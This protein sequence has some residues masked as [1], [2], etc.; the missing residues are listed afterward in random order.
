MDVDLRSNIAAEARAKI[1]YER[2]INFTD[3]L[4][5]IE[6]LQFL[7]GVHG[8]AGEHGKPAF[9]I[10]MIPPTPGL[11]NQYFDD[12]TGVGDKG[13]SMHEVR[14]IQG[15][16][17]NPWAPAFAQFASPGAGTRQSNVHS[18]DKKP[19]KKMRELRVEELQDVLHA[20][21]QL[22]AALPKMVQAADNP[23]LKEAFEK[24][25]EQTQ[26]QVD[27]LKQV[28]K[29]LGEEA[30]PKACKAMMGLEEGSETSGEREKK[31]ELSADLALITAAQ[32]VEH[33]E[34]SGYGTV[35]ALAR[36]IGEF[37]VARLLSHTLGEE[38]IASYLLTEVAKPLVQQLLAEDM[39]TAGTR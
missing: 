5:T 3:G 12:S 22:V 9:S 13:N 1:V 8:C 37:D 25:L 24:H 23:K 29:L 34:I 21:A 20:E 16:N 2:L 31:D 6:A 10:G 14:G 38:E 30:K 11:V 39:K 28:F 18:E 36:Q 15:L 26:G 27:R 17:G 19:A 35:R 7:M 4:G 32:K 33:Y